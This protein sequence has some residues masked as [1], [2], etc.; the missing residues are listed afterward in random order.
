[1]NTEPLIKFVEDNEIVT[2]PKPV[3]NEPAPM[4]PLMDISSGEPDPRK[5]LLG[6]RFLCVGG[7]C[8]FIGPSG[9]GKSSASAQQDILWSIGK[10]AFGIRPQRPLRILTIQAENDEEDIAEMRDGVLR[11]LELTDEEIEQCRENLFYANE[12]RRTGTNF[13]LAVRTHLEKARL[14]GKSFDLLRIDPFLAYLGD[15]PIDTEA[16]AAF[17]RNGL[18]P[19]L[20]EFRVGCIVNHHTPKVANRDTSAWRA[21]DWA[22]AGGGSADITNWARAIL[23]ID[24]TYDQSTFKFIAAKRGARIGW[25]NASGE[26]EVFR[27]F[28]HASN[29]IYWRPADEADLQAVE[30]AQPAKGKYG[31]AKPRKTPE[32]MIALVPLTGSILKEKLKRLARAAGFTKHGADEI[33]KEIIA[34]GLVHEWKIKRSK[35]NDEKQISR[36]EQNLV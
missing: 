13:L 17:L 19:I 22:Y 1:M 23:V 35:T 16:T 10:E 26:R 14:Q 4:I 20:N 8:L 6:N 29:G 21:S 15:D 11:G 27:H 30:S 5:T 33:L 25:T 32:E 28:C 24:P 12:I 18:N 9:I 3:A 36:H 34:D 7:G 2:S 31:N